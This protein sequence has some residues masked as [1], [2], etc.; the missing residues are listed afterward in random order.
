MKPFF[1]HQLCEDTAQQHS[2]ERVIRIPE[3]LTLLNISRSTLYRWIKNKKI[4]QPLSK[5]GQ[6]IG[7]TVSSYRAWL[8][9]R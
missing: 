9:S 2:V 5:N 1:K 7:W 6:I 8:K 3:M 4:I